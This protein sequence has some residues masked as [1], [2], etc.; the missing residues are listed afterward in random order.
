MID[1]NRLFQKQTKCSFVVYSS[2]Q[3]P[4][5]NPKKN[6]KIKKVFEK[7]DTNH[8]MNNI[9]KNIPSMVCK[10]S[11]TFLKQ[12]LLREKEDEP[13]KLWVIRRRFDFSYFSCKDEN[14]YPC[15]AAFEDQDL[16]QDTVQALK[17]I[18]EFVNSES[19]LKRPYYPLIIEKV[20][21]TYLQSLCDSSSLNLFIFSKSKTNKYDIIVKKFWFPKR[22]SSDII[23]NLENIYRIS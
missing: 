11:H 14:G 21:L 19:T 3:K 17:D 6:T 13:I 2:K 4:N 18:D 23:F 8:F 20:N 1:Y 10:K 9:V 12:M 22:P 16:A 5:P 7:K 15:I